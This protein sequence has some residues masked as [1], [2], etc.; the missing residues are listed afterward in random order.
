M[1]VMGIYLTAF[2]CQT[3]RSVHG[4]ICD[5][6]FSVSFQPFPKDSD[7]LL[8]HHALD[9]QTDEDEENGSGRPRPIEFR[10]KV[11]VKQAPA[12][13]STEQ[14]PISP[15]AKLLKEEEK[16]SEPRMIPV[17][18]AHP[19]KLNY[20][21]VDGISKHPSRQGFV[22]VSERALVHD[23]LQALMKVAAPLTSSSS[24]RVW[25]KRGKHGTDSGDGYEVVHLDSLDGK[26]MKKEVKPAPPI[27]LVGEWIR[28]HGE[29]ELIKDFQVL[30][31]TKPAKGDWPRAPLELEN[32][33]KVRVNFRW[34]SGMWTWV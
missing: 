32:R 3:L 16:R 23:T 11:I 18:E 29:V 12:A 10:R 15:M 20:S 14:H 8:H 33:I 22:L 19:V 21:I 13:P 24:R 31:E 4:V 2:G 7:V 6:G 27:M 17:V 25:S 1:S 34:W 26:L 30:V 9:G 5:D 28:T